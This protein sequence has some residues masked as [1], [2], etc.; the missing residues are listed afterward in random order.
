MPIRQNILRKGKAPKQNLLQFDVF[1]EETGVLGDLTTSEFFNISDFPSVLPTG[2]SSFLIEGSGLLKPEVE[3]KTEI[4]DA[5]GNP[6][7]HYAIPGYDKELP[8]RRIAVEVYQD[9]VVNGVGT[10]TILGE[11]DPKQF[12]IPTD[13][14]DTYNIRF[15]APISINKTINNTEPI[16]FYG[17]PTISVS[18]LVKGVAE[19]V[20]SVDNLTTTITGSV[21]A[22]VDKTT[23]VST[24]PNTYIPDVQKFE[25]V[26]NS[27]QKYRGK[28]FGTNKQSSILPPRPQTTTTTKRSVT[29]VLKELE[30]SNDNSSNK[31]SSALKG[32]TITFQN[33]NLT[34]R[35]SSN[36]SLS[37]TEFTLPTTFETDILDIENSTTFTTTTDYIVTDNNTN[38]N[39]KAGLNSTP[40]TMSF[41]SQNV[42]I[43]ESQVF[44]RSFANMT[45]GNLQTFSGDTYKAK[46]YM[47]EDGSS[48]EFEPIYETLVESQ[49]ELVDVG[50]VSGFDGV[51]NFT[52]QSIIDNN[53]ITSSNLA[54]ATTND[55]TILDGVLLSGSNEANGDTFTFVTKDVYSLQNNQPYLVEFKTAAKQA[56]KTQSDGTTN[57]DARLEVFLTGP[58]TSE[59]GEELSL[60]DVDL[61][62]I[63]L[64]N[65]DFVELNKLQI[66]D[67]QSHNLTSS[68]SGSLGFRVHA[69]EFILSDV[70][71]RPFSETNFSPGFFKANV[72]MPKAVK[73]GQKYDFLVEFYDAN[74]NLAEAVAIADDVVFNGPPQIIADGT[75]GLLTG[76]MFL[77]SVTG[78]GIE[79]HGGSAYIRSIGYNGFDRTIGENLGGFMMFSGSVSESINTSQSYEGVGLEIVDAHGTTDR[80]LKFRTNPS[81]FT[82]QT[83]QF[84]LGKDGQFISGS[85]GNIVISSS[86]FFLGGENT[87]VSGANDKL[88]ISSSNFHLDNDG[89]VIMQGTITAEAGGTIGGFDIGASS[90]A[91]GNVFQLSSSTNTADPASFISSSAFKVSAGG[92]ITGS[93]I[94]LTGG[95][96]T[97]GVTVEGTFSANSILTPASIGGSPTTP[98]NASASID[99]NGNAVF[100]SGSI[101][102]FRMDA[103][104]LFSDSAEFVVT[105]STGQITG[106]QVLFTGGVIGGFE[107]GPSIISSSN[108]NLILKDSGQI[109]GSNVLFDGGVIGGFALTDNAIS[110]SNNNLKLFDSGVITGSRVFFDGGRIGGFAILGDAA[111]VVDSIRSEDSSLILSGSGQITGS[112]VLFD[113][114]KIGGFELTSSAIASTN[115]N[116]IMSSSGQITGSTVLF[117][118]G[119]IGGFSIV[120][121]ADNVADAIHSTDKKLILSG[122]GQITGSN[123]LLDGGKIGGFELTEDAIASSN[124][125]LIM[126]SSGRITAS[127]AKI[128]GSDVDIDVENFEL[129]TTGLQISSTAPSM[130]LGTGQELMMRAT[131]NSPYIAL[132]PSVALVDKA[133]GE[134]GVFL[135]V[136]GGSTPLFSLLNG[137]NFLKWNGTALEIASPKFS[138]STAGNI[139]ATG[140]T[141]GGFVISD[142]NLET[143]DFASGVKGIR[144]STANNGSLEA[145]EARI[146]GTLSTTVFEKES[147]NAVG[148][149]LVVANSTAITGSSVFPTGSFGSTDTTMSVENSSGFVNG[150]ILVIKKVTGTG[151]TT[152]YVQVD[153]AS[154]LSTDDNDLTGLL[155]VTR[156]LNDEF[157]PGKHS[158]SLSEVTASAQS[159]EPGQ[160]VVSTGRIGTGYIRL[161][162]N[163]SDTTTPYIDIVERTGSKVFEVDLKARLGD[164]SGLSSTLV[165]SSPGFGLFSENVFL[166]GKVTATSGKIANWEIDG[167]KLESFNSSTKGIVLDADPSTPKITIQENSDNLIELFHT[168][169]T[170]FGIKGRV[171]GNNLLQLGSTNQIGGFGITATA[172][173]SSN[174]NLILKNNGQI[175]ASAAKISGDI[176]ITSGDLAGIDADS[177]SGSSTIISAS[178]AAGQSGSIAFDAHATQVVL[179]SAGMDVKNT[180]AQ[181]IASFGASAKLLGGPNNTSDFAEVNGNGMIV[182]ANSETASIMDNAGTTIMGGTA[183]AS[184]NSDGLTLISAGVTGSL[185]SATTSSMFG[186]S[187]NDRVE[188]TDTGLKVYESNKQMLNVGAA[189]LSI[190]DTSNNLVSNFGSDVHLNAGDIYLGV[191]GSSG[192]WIQIDSS[193]ILIKRNNSNKLRIRDNGVQML[194]SDVNSYLLINGD[195]ITLTDNNI[196]GSIIN[197]DGMA[198]FGSSGQTTA[199]FNSDGITLATGGRTGSLF[200]SETSSMF[201]GTNTDERVE[202]TGLGMKVYEN[203]KQMVDIGSSGLEVFDTSDNQVAIFG[204]DT[205]L[206]GGT[207]TIR[208][209][210]NNNDKLVITEDSLTISDNNNAVASFGANTI[211]E[212]GTITIRNTT[213]NNDKVVLAENSFKIFD[214]NNEVAEFAATTTIGDT[215]GQHISI[216][217]DSIDIKTGANVTVLSASADGIDMSGSIKAGAGQIGGMTIDEDSIFTGTKDTAGFASNNGD[218]TVGTSGIHSKVFFVNTSDG[219]AGFAGTV[220]I[221]GTDLT[222]SNTLNS[223]TSKDDVGL[224]NV[225]NQ[226]AATIQ[227]NTLSAADADDVGLGNV[228]NKNSQ[229][230]AQDGLI[231]GVTLTGGGITIGS[232][233]AIKSSGKDSLADNTN[234]FFLGTSDSGTSY[235]FAIGDGSESLKW[236][237]SA[238][239]LE[240]TGTVTADAGEIGGWTINSAHLQ[241]GAVKLD[242]KGFVEATGSTSVGGSSKDTKATLSGSSIQ[243]SILA[244][245]RDDFAGNLLNLV[246]LHT[247]QSYV[248]DVLLAYAS[249][250]DRDDVAFTRSGTSSD[251]SESL[252]FSAGGSG[253]GAWPSNIFIRASG[254]G[255]TN[256]KKAVVETSMS[257]NQLLDTQEANNVVEIAFQNLTEEFLG[258]PSSTNA[259]KALVRYKVEIFQNDTNSATGAELLKTFNISSVLT[260]GASASAVDINQ[261]I[262]LNKRFFFAKITGTNYD[263]LSSGDGDDNVYKFSQT[264]APIVAVKYLPKVNINGVGF[265][266]FAGPNQEVKLGA[267]NEIVGDLQLRETVADT[268]G[269]LQVEG[270]GAFGT[271][272]IDDTFDLFV[273]G[274]IG[275]TGNITGFYSSDV[276]LKENIVDI[277]EGLSIINQLRPVKFDWKDDSPF[278]HLYPTE[279]GLIAQEV[280]EVVPEIVGTMKQDYKGINYESLV[281]LLISSIKELTK[282]VEELEERFIKK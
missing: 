182:V 54:S 123:V 170:N 210:A 155:M 43:V 144:L 131:G 226:S 75:D 247:S 100:R 31:L 28:K 240:V 112:N 190:F 148:G 229:N 172:I 174:N 199:S 52:T 273:E 258:A 169:G 264:A 50:S 33:P 53:W 99:A 212:G 188:V 187:S 66:A 141:I 12:N 266:T 189:G 105:G 245:Q 41:E 29:Y 237:G 114:G 242:R 106:S 139:T 36:Q 186:A 102:G 238:G 113:A 142:N 121:S 243:G 206:T 134:T 230:Q 220:T 234:G 205:T 241:G 25:E 83:D 45:V 153:S 84:F 18:E 177:I 59:I 269:N 274:E 34:A 231:S 270:K 69:G 72:P 175:T 26:G 165:G 44:K 24:I 176:T 194:G 63:D 20:S 115:G 101:G 162:A 152:E 180:S 201:G 202:V 13:F 68:P 156:S 35:D 21:E 5:Q 246:E 140:G 151:F 61:S 78:S 193:Q 261:P 22:I 80:F 173:S 262:V 109:T 91:A 235:D 9:D 161:N 168:T 253:A 160:V 223:N 96:I 278:A 118:G 150:E 95:T 55:D 27:L 167:N 158:G 184:L 48:G 267:K 275:A 136:A 98:A 208:S 233:G 232:G 87:F 196:T 166:T 164:L 222:T 224:G 125:N 209:S 282:R 221:G 145:E 128:A 214:N 265:Q 192:D 254:T 71:L 215:S 207:I 90:L 146:R 248:D 130:S 137:S 1:R 104:T 281:P 143:T 17:D 252:T 117:D 179:S 279:Y 277:K 2:N 92:I 249:G 42:G 257:D 23:I 11:L 6:I 64:S 40:V 65:N 108:D 272:T 185:I 239:T 135:G 86:N 163:P 119:K 255:A 8:A 62:E 159:Y 200:T 154:R 211:L 85:N 7:F 149:Q 89:S 217:S 124:G 103:T 57:K 225:D 147:I 191:T 259:G 219:T 276:R 14:Q 79:V 37:S 49:N 216:D 129:S 183:T 4:L 58:I 111:N 218:L 271:L 197:S 77:G 10:L 110:S 32:A 171:G 46:I 251:Q 181:T 280:E 126:S 203:N 94:L 260:L 133:Y 3:L 138:L 213:N 198:I 228:E 39:Q 15:S 70:R 47:K 236:D 227:S 132:Q 195:G 73:R 82:V 16:R 116:L 256:G 127:S 76:S 157:E 67:F 263:E 51:G 107:L 120:G 88:E 38:Q 204:S 244:I 74:N 30:S 56:D 268:R 250:S 122:S 19:T 178:A 81:E 93:N 97:S 60:G